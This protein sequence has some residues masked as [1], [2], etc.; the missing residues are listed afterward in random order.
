MFPI[1]DTDENGIGYLHGSSLVAVSGIMHLTDDNVTISLGLGSG[2]CERSSAGVYREW[3]RP[4]GDGPG[5]R[6]ISDLEISRTR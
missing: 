1:S 4:D 5:Y 3:N 2:A 6:N